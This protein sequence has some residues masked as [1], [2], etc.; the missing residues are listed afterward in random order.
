MN[1]CT[2]SNLS[3]I[4]IKVKIIIFRVNYCMNTKKWF[5]TAL[6]YSI[7]LLSFVLMFV[8]IRKNE[9]NKSNTKRCNKNSYNSLTTTYTQAYH[10]YIWR[11]VNMFTSYIISTFILTLILIIL[12]T[13]II[14][15]QFQ[16]SWQ[17]KFGPTIS[18]TYVTIHFTA[19]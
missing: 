19:Q 13:K 7:V 17:I 1:N 5:F 14:L 12:T 3:G 15:N 16:I 11:I 10:Y 18:N 2:L 8:S 9:K 4:G 6:P